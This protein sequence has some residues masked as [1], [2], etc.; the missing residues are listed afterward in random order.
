MPRMGKLLKDFLRGVLV[1]GAKGSTQ[2]GGV[3][4]YRQIE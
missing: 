2:S 4:T 1:M 3:S